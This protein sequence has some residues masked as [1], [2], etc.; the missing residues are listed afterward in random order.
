V[1]QF[2]RYFYASSETVDAYLLLY[3]WHKYLDRICF[4]DTAGTS[5]EFDHMR[6]ALRESFV[7]KV[8]QL[9]NGPTDRTWDRLDELL[10]K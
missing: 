8:N 5:G 7:A 3:V 2:K 10:M 1:S 4:W 6:E 9:P